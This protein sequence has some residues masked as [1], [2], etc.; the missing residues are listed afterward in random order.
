MVI[1]DG[2]GV[3]VPADIRETNYLHIDGIV[4]RNSS[5][6]V[7][8]VI[9]TAENKIHHIKLTRCGFSDSSSSVLE[10]RK[11]IVH[12]TYTEHCLLEDCYAWGNGRYHFY[13]HQ[14]SYMVLRRCV[15]RYDRGYGDGGFDNMASFQ[16]YDSTPIVLQNCISID[17]DQGA[18]YIDA[19]EIDSTPKS[20]WFSHDN[21]SAFG[22]IGLNNPY[23]SAFFEHDDDGLNNELVD[24]VFW[25]YNAG[26]RTR[27]SDE[28]L[29]IRNCV[30]GDLS[31]SVNGNAVGVKSDFS[32]NCDVLDSV[33]YDCDWAGFTNV[34]GLNTDYNNVYGNSR[35]DYESCSAAENDLS[36]DPLDGV[37]GNNNPALKYLPRIEPD[38]DLSG[39][40]SDGGDIGANILYKIGVDGTLWGEAGWNETTAESLWPFPNE[41]VIKEKMAEYTYDDGS[42]G[43]PEISGERGFCSDGDGLYGGPITLTS[44][45]WEYLGNECPE[46]ICDYTSDTTPPSAPSGLGVN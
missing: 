41:D 24:S 20:V 21:S 35:I 11:D 9:G 8:D 12:F 14:S 31:S 29:T 40:G 28:V 26:I 32:E 37:P 19:G 1:I 4:F 39:A 44:Y 25:T 45:I 17:G 13:I 36:I 15:D 33:I 7:F 16:L 6:T 5:D 2:E 43:E 27:D 30:I 46:E 22:F 23:L 34:N 42:G 3:R 18:F 10:P 38:S